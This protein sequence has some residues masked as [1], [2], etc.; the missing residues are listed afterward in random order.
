MAGT[1]NPPKGRDGEERGRG[2]AGRG[3]YLT[4]HCHHQND[5]C[6]IKTDAGS[7]ES[8]FWSFRL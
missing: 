3:V 2:E 1:K 6:I 5:F 8:H 7:N 4:L